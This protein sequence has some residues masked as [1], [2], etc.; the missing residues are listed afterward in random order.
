MQKIL[1]NT[2]S[3][4][5]EQCFGSFNSPDCKDSRLSSTSEGPA[6]LLAMDELISTQL[7]T[8]RQTSSSKEITAALLD[9]DHLTDSCLAATL[10]SIS[11]TYHDC[12]YHTCSQQ[13]AQPDTHFIN[14]TDSTQPLQNIYHC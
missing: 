9:R 13:P 14:A 7:E 10:Y 11:Q 12:D 8:D 3:D 6:L 2:G 1:V 5:G 4:F